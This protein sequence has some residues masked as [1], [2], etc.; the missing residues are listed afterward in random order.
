M[1]FLLKSILTFVLAISMIICINPV[2]AQDNPVFSTNDT[3]TIVFQPFITSQDSVE[4]GKNIIFDASKTTHPDVNKELTFTWDFGDGNKDE[5]VEVVNNYTS[6]GVKTVKLKVFDGES[7]KEI[8]K[9]VFVY[10]KIIIFITDKAGSKDRIEGFKNYARE[11]D[12]NIIV[13]ESYASVTDFI[14]EEMLK[15]KLTEALDNLRKIDQIV[16]WTDGNAGLNALAGV[17]QQQSQSETPLNFENKTILVLQED[18]KSAS[19][20]FHR[21]DLL[22]PLGI[23]I[24]K[25]AAIYPFIDSENFKGFIDRMKNEGYVYTLVDAETG[26]L[27]IW[28]FVSYFVN[29]LIDSGIPAN[30]VILILMLPAI[31]MIVAFMKQVIGI[32]T[33]GI[34]TPTIITL[35]FW[36]LGLK[37]G[38]LTILIIFLVGTG[39]R[40]IL[41]KFRLLYIPKMAI[42]LTMVAIA[43][44]AM[45]IISLK[46]N[47]FDAQ[48]FSLSIFPML[49]LSTLT[50][51]FVNA[52]SEEGFKKAIVLTFATLFVSTIAFFIITE[53]VV[54]SFMLSYPEII[55]FII[56]IDIFLGKWTGLRLV[57][58]IRFRE[59]L[60]HVDEE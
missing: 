9:E 11:K 43:I 29:Y 17:K 46:F 1:K 3:E 58:R 26:K 59:V 19:Q 47:L 30:T 37:L 33:F 54:Q 8:Q 56:V 14:S 24:A 50:E 41:K 7:T 55:I 57:E 39:S 27:Q 13:I 22:K 31:A 45:L 18:S 53:E 5:G 52:Q 40:Y 25:E 36:I 15:S 28:N 16:I 38:L 51:K 48:F 6:L 10:K 2:F 49:I 44:F 12:I 20:V 4:L 42:V 35:S 34:Y 32:T 21:Y 23:V 60:R